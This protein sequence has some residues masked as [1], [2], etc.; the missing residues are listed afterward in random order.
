MASFSA[1]NK[2]IFFVAS[3][4]VERERLGE[5]QNTISHVRNNRGADQPPGDGRCELPHHVSETAGEEQNKGMSR[6]EASGLAVYK[7]GG[8]RC[9]LLL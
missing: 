7:A 3:T 5:L 2:F 9:W 1:V 4:V 6:G 8:R